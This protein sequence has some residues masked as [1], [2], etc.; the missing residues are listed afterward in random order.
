LGSGQV[1]G[2]P[3]TAPQLESRRELI[4]GR[5]LFPGFGLGRGFALGF[6][7]W[8]RPRNAHTE[9]NEPKAFLQQFENAHGSTSLP[10]FSGISEPTVARFSSWSQAEQQ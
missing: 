2:K 8:C 10:P 6:G 3:E 4:A 7:L 9:Q 1:N 5:G